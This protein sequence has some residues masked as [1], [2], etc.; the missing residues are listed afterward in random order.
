MFS[1]IY[2][3][4]FYLS[5]CNVQQL[6]LVNSLIIKFNSFSIVFF[7]V[8]ETLNPNN[9]AIKNPDIILVLKPTNVLR[10]M[11]NQSL[12]W[13][14]LMPIDSTIDEEIFSDESLPKDL[15]KFFVLMFF[16][17]IFS[18]IFLPLHHLPSL[19]FT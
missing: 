14:S 13:N 6:S 3:N 12:I 1:G 18:E 16:F 10:H 15:E 11:L 9:K 19:P 2:C 8:A 4:H 7:I 5:L 17:L